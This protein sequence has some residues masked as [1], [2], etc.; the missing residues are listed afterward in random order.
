MHKIC[1]F[2]LLPNVRY[3]KTVGLPSPTNEIH[4]L[5]LNNV[6][7]VTREYGV[8]NSLKSL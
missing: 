4:F 7:D 2:S 1:L 3:K 6:Q 8:T 5:F